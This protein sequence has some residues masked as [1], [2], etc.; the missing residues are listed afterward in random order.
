MSRGLPE[1]TSAVFEIT[2]PSSFYA[3]PPLEFQFE[4]KAYF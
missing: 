2:R 3:V 1:A 4:S